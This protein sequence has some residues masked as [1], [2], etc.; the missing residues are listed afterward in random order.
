[1]ER[2]NVLEVALDLLEAVVD[3]FSDMIENT[4]KNWN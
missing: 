2:V 4:E 1:V 3:T